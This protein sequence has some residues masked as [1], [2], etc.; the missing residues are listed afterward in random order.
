MELKSPAHIKFSWLKILI[1][2]VLSIILFDGCFFNSNPWFAAD[3]TGLRFPQIEQHKKLENPSWSIGPLGHYSADQI[4]LESSNL[5]PLSMGPNGRHWMGTDPLGRDVLSL[6]IQ[7]I[8]W[9][10]LIAFGACI[11]A[12][13]ISLLLNYFLGYTLFEKVGFS[14]LRWCFGLLL[15]LLGLFY[16]VFTLGLSP[17]L[18]L[19]LFISL[20]YFGLAI[21]ITRKDKAID[22]DALVVQFLKV[23][24]SLPGIMILLVLSALFAGT[25]FWGLIF[26]LGLVVWPFFTRLLRGEMLD[27][28]N[29]DFIQA[30][31]LS[32]ADFFHTFIYQILPNIYK[33]LLIT[34]CFGVNG[35]ILLEATLSFLG[36]G[37]TGGVD[38]LGRQ[39]SQGRAH[40]NSWWLVVFPGLALFLILLFFNRLANRL[41]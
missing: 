26:L 25:A 19:I 20:L 6:V 31:K 38:T 37:L 22:G 40:L 11:I 13:F 16:L 35:I 33:P 23:F 5:A 7:G 4:N 18:Y 41:R 3:E 39:I 21:I 12:L 14:W 2:F 28:I 29:E 34:L 17:D 30:S 9:S 32:G 15:M 27:V 10:M 24:K 36:I 1:F 8:K